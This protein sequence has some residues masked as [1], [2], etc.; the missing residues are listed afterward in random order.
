VEVNDKTSKLVKLLYKSQF[1][2]EVIAVQSV[3]KQKPSPSNNY[4]F[5]PIF[6]QFKGVVTLDSGE[7]FM[8]FLSKNNKNWDLTSK[9]I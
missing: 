4:L 9:S 7:Q 5:D 2:E 3:D 6:N 8:F 1:K